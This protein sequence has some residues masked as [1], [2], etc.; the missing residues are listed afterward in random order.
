MNDNPSVFRS[1]LRYLNI[2]YLIILLPAAFMPPVSRPQRSPDF[3]LMAAVLLLMCVNAIG[4]VISVRIV[5]NIFK[6]FKPEEYAKLAA[7]GIWSGVK[8]EASY[9]F[10]VIRA[11]AYCLVVLGGVLVCSSILYGVQ[12]GQMDFGFTANFFTNAWDRVVRVSEVTETMYWFRNQPG[13]FGWTGIPGLLIYGLSTFL[14]IIILSFLATIWLLLIPFRI[15]VN[16]PPT[17]S[18]AVR[19]ISA[20]AAVFAMCLLTSFAFRPILFF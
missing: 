3:H 4:D 8:Q 20:E 2:Y 14:P 18:P 19:V 5:L 6:K 10:A 1:F 13:P 7:D 15:A 16:L 11:G 12:V 9:Y 17:T